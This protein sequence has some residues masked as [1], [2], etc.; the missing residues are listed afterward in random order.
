M[1]WLFV[2]LA[3]ALPLILNVLRWRRD[4]ERIRALTGARR[5]IPYDELLR[6]GAPRVSFLIAAWNEEATLARCID[7]VLSLGYPDLEVVLCAGGTDSTWQIASGFSDPRVALLP[8]QAGDGKQKALMHCLERATGEIV[9]LID[10]D[11]L[12]TPPAFARVLYPILGGAEHAVTNIPCTPFPEQ[13]A[14]PFAI[15]QCASWVYTSIY[16]PAYG[17]SLVGMNAAIRRQALE[18]AGGFDA[19]VRAGGDFDLGKR[20]LRAGFRIRYEA[21][22]SFPIEFQTNPRV[23]LRQ[24]ARWLRN[25]VI[26]GLRFGAYREAASCLLT[27]LVGFAMLAL[28]ATAALG[29]FL[30]AP[31]SISAVLLAIWLLGLIHALFSR[32]RYLKAAAAWLGIPIP[33]NTLALSPVLLIVDFAAWAIPLFQYPW[34]SLRELW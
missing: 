14:S 1:K 31:P 28:P 10:A 11:C 8:Q 19:R 30:G 17:S 16:H 6:H 5:K 18:K 27:S 12:I 20:L 26:H 29:L 4:R 33:K 21:D 23:Y 24:Q 7:A 25:V 15:S 9:Y 3:L 34:K 32:I 22:A 2:A 13:L